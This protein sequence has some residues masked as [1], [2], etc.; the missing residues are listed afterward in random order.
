MRIG[1]AAAAVGATP[2]ALRF[3]EQRGLL[4]APR[5]TR[6]GQRDYGP[7]ELAVL[8]VI[9]QL[10]ALGLTVEDLRGI[11]DR[12]PLLAADP[13][14]CRGSAAA[15]APE[16]GVVGAA[17][18]ERRIA[19]LDADIERLTRLRDALKAGLADRRGAARPACS[20]AD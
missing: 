19:A 15:D 5:R 13:R 8:R 6:S 2:R 1:D 9:R 17:V 3:Y 16:E 4:P 10:L 11:A 12:L 20:P 7:G 14:P 18:V